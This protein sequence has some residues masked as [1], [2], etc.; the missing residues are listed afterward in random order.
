MNVLLKRIGL[1]LIVATLSLGVSAQPVSRKKVG[2]VLSG[3]GAKGVA[4]I[5]ALKVLEEAGIPVDYIAGTSMGAIVGGLYS[6]G[7]T[8][9]MLDSLV[10]TQNWLALLGDRVPRN[11]MSLATREAQEKYLISM[12]LTGEKKLKMPSGLLG[13]QNV[14]NLLAELTIDYHDS[15]HFDRLPIPFACVAYDMVTGKAIVLDEGYLPQ[16]IRAS[17]SMPGAFEP[18]RI[19][20]MVLVDGGI[21]N[22]FPVDV[23]RDMG[24]DVIVGIDV[25]A[26]LHTKD[27]LNNVADLFDQLTNFT[28]LESY[29]ANKQSA[30]FYVHPDI[31]PYGAASFSAAAIDTLIRRGEETMRAH[32]DELIALKQRIGIPADSM[33]VTRDRMDLDKPLIIRKI[34]F[35]GLRTLNEKQVSKIIRLK[36]NTIL[37]ASDLHDAVSR[38]QGIGA[39][40]SVYYRLDGH[41]PY[42]LT[43]YVEEGSRNSVSFGFRFDTEEMAAVLLNAT[44]AVRGFGNSVF[45]ITGRLSENPYIRTAYQLGNRTGRQMSVSYMY[46]YNDFNLYSWGRKT[47]N[48]DYDYHLI[49]LNF[50]NIRLRNFKVDVGLKYEYFDYRTV[51]TSADNSAERMK[52]QGLINYYATALYETLDRRYNPTR[53]LWLQLKYNLATTNF[54]TYEN[55]TPFS[56]LSLDFNSAL[57]VSRRVAFLPGLFGRVLIGNRIAYSAR[58][59]MGGTV[60]GRYMPQQMPFVGI[61]HLEQFKNTV[62]GARLDFRVRLWEKT[63]VSLKGNYAAQSDDF[64]DI[65]HAGN[66]WGMGLAY[67]YNTLI[68]PIDLLVDY[69]NHSKKVGVYFNLGYYF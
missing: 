24:A 58:N 53:G 42:D 29:E 19:N 61:H 5:G 51:L 56:A 67:S 34:N 6:I 49:D 63:F 68:G 23:A 14:Y 25:G 11:K 52:S 20:D 12:S 55:G 62:L 8:P 3:G 13:G 60:A 27:E 9:Q 57:S 69:S 10:R 30:D 46:C 41:S 54:V 43:F 7:Y 26:G 1:L 47:A 66:I 31:E 33:M 38:L 16:A 4:H 18:V 39:F 40:S 22:N 44:L 21:S 2:L 59:F 50:S 15:L 32:W 37:T 17:M 45:D 64:F 36:E 35:E 28:G 65:F 48:L